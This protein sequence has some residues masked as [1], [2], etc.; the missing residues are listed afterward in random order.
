MGSRKAISL[1]NELHLIAKGIDGVRLTAERLSVDASGEEGRMAGVIASQL[2]ILRERLLLLD[3]VVRGDVDPRLLW[4]TEND[5][6]PLIDDG[7]HDDEDV[8]FQVWSE[9]AELRRYRRLWK[10]ARRRLQRRKE[11]R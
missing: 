7:T 6:L 3:R 1:S 9:R 2:T 10:M 4:C 11:G 8:T 5:A